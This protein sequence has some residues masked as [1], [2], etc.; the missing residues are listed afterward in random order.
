MA[1]A[2]ANDLVVLTDDLDCDLVRYARN[3]TECRA[4]HSEEVN[5]DSI[6]QHVLTALRQMEAELQRDAL[7]TIDPKRTRLRVLPL[8]SRSLS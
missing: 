4:I 7:L 5:P 8:Y 2:A 1:H 6:G 3:Q